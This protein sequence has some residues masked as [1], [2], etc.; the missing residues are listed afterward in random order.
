M[1]T[2]RQRRGGATTLDEA[3]KDGHTE[4]PGDTDGTGAATEPPAAPRGRPLPS[5][6]TQ[7]TVVAGDLTSK[8]V[9]LYGEPKIGKSTLASEWGG[10]NVLFF[11]C[12]GELSDL[13]VYR[14]G[15]TDWT[16]FR[17]NAA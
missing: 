9:L 11:D 13:E 14:L 16:S 15:C 10:G 4:P 17:E 3:V 5:L 2:T 1:A 6:P 12:A 7:R 8:S